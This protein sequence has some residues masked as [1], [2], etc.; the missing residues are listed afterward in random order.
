MFRKLGMQTSGS[1]TSQSVRKTITAPGD[2][3]L[4]AVSGNYYNDIDITLLNTKDV[5]ATCYD[6]STDMEIE[7]LNYNAISATS[8][9][10]WMPVNTV[11]VRI[12]IMG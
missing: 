8:F 2:W 12:V 9:R 1:G 10:V 4:D 11:T 6:N 5:E 3:T 7:P